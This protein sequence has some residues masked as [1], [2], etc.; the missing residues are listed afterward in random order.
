[1]SRLRPSFSINFCMAFLG[2]AGTGL[3]SALGGSMRVMDSVDSGMG[4]FCPVF[5]TW[6]GFVQPSS[7]HAQYLQRTSASARS[8]LHALFYPHLHAQRF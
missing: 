3:T 6:Y 5:T 7:T 4:Q 1:M 8:Q 2:G